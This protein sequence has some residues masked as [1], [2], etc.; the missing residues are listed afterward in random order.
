MQSRRNTVQSRRD[1]TLCR[2]IAF[3]FQGFVEEDPRKLDPQW[4][5][6]MMNLVGMSISAVE[7]KYIDS[8]CQEV[9]CCALLEATDTK[10]EDPFFRFP[11][12]SIMSSLKV[13]HLLIIVNKPLI[14]R[15]CSL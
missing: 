6:T 7:Q 14:D 12:M 1:R 2:Q 3:I 4:A 15:S 5:I 11:N 13:C 10:T 8:E 9:I